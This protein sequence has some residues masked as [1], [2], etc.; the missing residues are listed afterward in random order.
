MKR[1]R[2]NEFREF[3][4]CCA[5]MAVKNLKLALRVRLLQDTCQAAPCDAL[6]QN[7]VNMQVGNEGL[8]V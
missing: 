4:N 3:E 2:T 5:V 6:A 8:C 1:H 7:D